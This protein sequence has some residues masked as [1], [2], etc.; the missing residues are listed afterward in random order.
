MPQFG[1]DITVVEPEHTI[2]VVVGYEDDLDRPVPVMA[3]VYEDWE[4]VF[5]DMD[6]NEVRIAKRRLTGYRETGEFDGHYSKEIYGTRVVLEYRYT[7]PNP[8]MELVAAVPAMRVLYDRVYPQDTQLHQGENGPYMYT[9]P[10]LMGIPAG[11][12]ID[13]LNIE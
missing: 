2:Q 11:W 6:G 1:P 4:R 8:T 10:P 9:P 7:T 12:R 13:H 5:L 3:A